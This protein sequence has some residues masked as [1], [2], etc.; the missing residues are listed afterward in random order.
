MDLLNYGMQYSMERPLKI[1]WT[2]LPVETKRSIKLL[3]TKLQNSYR[4]IAAKKMKKIY[5]ADN[6]HKTMQKRTE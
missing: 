6:Y 2:N 5:N 4:I 3:D 1:Y